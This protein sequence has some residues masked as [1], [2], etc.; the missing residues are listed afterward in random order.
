VAKINFRT[1]TSTVHGRTLYMS[2]PN[3]LAAP[4]V[5]FL[6]GFLGKILIDWLRRSNPVAFY[7]C[8]PIPGPSS[9]FVG[10][11]FVYELKLQIRNPGPFS[12]SV[13]LNGSQPQV[14]GTTAQPFN[15]IVPPGEK[16]CVEAIR[17]SPN[18][19]PIVFRLRPRLYS[20]RCGLRIGEL[21]AYPVSELPV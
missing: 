13:E 16:I 18:S 4:I 3:D 5:T 8:V 6:L 11:P 19:S 20:F 2:I 12:F 17:A 21:R 7:T 9:A 10:L 14:L 1:I 15:A